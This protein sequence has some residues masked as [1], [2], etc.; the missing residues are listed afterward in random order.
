MKKILLFVSLVWISLCAFAQT[1]QAIKYQTVARN[2]A[3]EILASQNISF[4]MTVL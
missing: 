1:P 2:N 3:G 4:R